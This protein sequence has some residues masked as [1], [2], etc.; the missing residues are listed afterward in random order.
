MRRWLPCSVK[1]APGLLQVPVPPAWCAEQQAGQS[2]RPDR[3]A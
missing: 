3:A 1:D 2:R